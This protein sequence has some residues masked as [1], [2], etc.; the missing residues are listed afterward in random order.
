M[1]YRKLGS[2]GTLV[3]SPALGTMN[4]G[5]P[6]TPEEE[7]FAQ[8]DAFIEAGGNLIDT[9]D[10]YNGG[11]A[12]KTVGRWLAAAPARRLDRTGEP[13]PGRARRARRRQR[14]EPGSLSLRLVWLR[15]ACPG[16]ERSRGPRCARTGPRERLG[17]LTPYLYEEMTW[18]TPAWVTPA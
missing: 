16:R 15:P 5:T 4:F 9:A 18:S 8:L 1:E 11:V 13:L 10:V 2:S 7:A 6:Q 12:E 17:S 14:P 3:S